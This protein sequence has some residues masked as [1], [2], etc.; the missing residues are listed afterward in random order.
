MATSRRTFLKLPR[1]KESAAAAQNRSGVRSLSWP[2][3]RTSTWCV[4]SQPANAG[5][6]DL[7][8]TMIGR[9]RSRMMGHGGSYGDGG[10]QHE[11]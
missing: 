9:V 5:A 8:I 11:G 2:L 4:S 6:Q 10:E 1:T 3:R 7:A